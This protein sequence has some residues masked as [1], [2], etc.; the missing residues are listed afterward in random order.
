M[1]SYPAL[2][3]YIGMLVRIENVDLTVLSENDGAIEVPINVGGGI[4]VSDQV[5][6]SNE[7]Y[8]IAR[9]GPA[10]PEGAHFSSITG[11]VTYFYAFKIAPR[12]AADF[13]Q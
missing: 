1:K 9:S 3:P 2:R 11:V 8:D 12:S 5:K 10:L 7:L 6:I 13:V 4:G